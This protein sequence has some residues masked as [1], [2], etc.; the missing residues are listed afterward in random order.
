[1]QSP[2]VFFLWNWKTFWPMMLELAPAWLWE[3]PKASGLGNLTSKL[4]S[5]S[6]KNSLFVQNVQIGYSFKEKQLSSSEFSIRNVWVVGCPP[7]ICK[8]WRSF[9]I[10]QNKNRNFPMNVCITSRRQIESLWAKTCFHTGEHKA[11]W[12]QG[13]GK[14][15]NQCTQI[16]TLNTNQ[17][18]RVLVHVKVVFLVFVSPCTCVFVFVW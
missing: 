10:C 9:A 16:Q 2:K 15:F 6:K 4:V 1:M 14:E 18:G 17:V 12:T 3:V 11:S 13:L 5:K 8:N 7:S